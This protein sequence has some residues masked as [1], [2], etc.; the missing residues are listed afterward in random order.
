MSNYNMKKERRRFLKKTLY[1]TPKLI[2]LGHLLNSVEASANDPFV[3]DTNNGPSGPITMFDY[4]KLK[5]NGSEI[6]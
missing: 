2:V 6:A 5:K 1:T 4:N 3:D